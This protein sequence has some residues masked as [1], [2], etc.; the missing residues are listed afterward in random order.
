MSRAICR[1]AGPPTRDR[2]RTCAAGKGVNGKCRILIECQG[3]NSHSAAPEPKLIPLALAKC[4]ALG[5]LVSGKPCGSQLRRCDRH[6]VV[7]TRITPCAGADRC[8]ATCDDRP[9]ES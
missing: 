7:T 8:C 4:P 1:H 2:W 5:S 6:H 3:C 9:P